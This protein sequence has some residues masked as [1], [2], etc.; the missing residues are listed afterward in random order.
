MGKSMYILTYGRK[1]YKDITRNIEGIY[2]KKPFEIYKL[3][4]AVI[5]EKVITVRVD[6]K[7]ILQHCLNILVQIPSRNKGRNVQTFNREFRCLK[8]TL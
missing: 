5:V 8:E 2:I 7:N 1:K 6:E 3:L 4:T